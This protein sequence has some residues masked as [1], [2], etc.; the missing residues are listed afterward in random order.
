MLA[1]KLLQQSLQWLPS[2]PGREASLYTAQA[3][4]AL[5]ASGGSLLSRQGSLHSGPAGRADETW[6]GCKQSHEEMG[7]SWWSPSL[8]LR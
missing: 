6:A 7:A 8:V 3:L 5:A 2:V 1:L 4:T